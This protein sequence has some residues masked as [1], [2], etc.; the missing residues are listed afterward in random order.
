[1]TLKK[2][3]TYLKQ[4]GY[5]YEVPDWISYGFIIFRNHFFEI[6]FF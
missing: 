5:Q 4:I 3:I 1:M 6:I 2:K